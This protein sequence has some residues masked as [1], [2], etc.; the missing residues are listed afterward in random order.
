LNRLK[1]FRLER[2]LPGGIR[3]RWK[4]HAFHGALEKLGYF[5][6]SKLS[7]RESTWQVELRKL[8]ADRHPAAI[9]KRISGCKCLQSNRLRKSN[10]TLEP[11]KKRENLQEFGVSTD[12]GA[13]W[14]TFLV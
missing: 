6:V 11:W 8:A 4:Q 13:M 3:T 7:I 10:G 14:C 12:K 9:S 1:C 5:S 2:Q